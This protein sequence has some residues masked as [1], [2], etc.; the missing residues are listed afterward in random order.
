MHNFANIPKMVQL[1]DE[2]FEKIKRSGLSGV[3]GKDIGREMMRMKNGHVFMNMSSCSYLGLNDF[4]TV[5]QGLLDGLEEAGGIQIAAAPLR[6]RLAIVDE[7]N[8]EFGNFMGC[9]AF[10]TWTCSLASFGILPLLAAGLFTGNKPPVMVYDKNAHFCM[11]YMK[12][13]CADETEVIT[14]NHNDMA[15]LE[16]ICKTKNPVVYLCE[17]LYSTGGVTCLDEIL[18]L[19]EKYGMYILIDEAHGLS[20]VGKN[21]KGLLIDKLGALNDRSFFIASLEKGF[22]AHGGGV[23]LFSDKKLLDIIERYGGPL[24]WSAPVPSMI[25]G[26]TRAC[27]KL[28]ADGTVDN[29]QKILHE[30]V[31]LFDQLMDIKESDLWS[32]VRVIKY[33]DEDELFYTGIRLFE[34]GFYTSTV[35]F[36]TVKGGNSG[37]HIM[38]RANM[39]DEELRKFAGLLKL[40]KLEWADRKRK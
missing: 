35:A 24:E 32:A 21:G 17:S 19:Q 27:L 30:K 10:M 16:K 12:A 28:H 29:L 3:T 5:K 14:I 15:A 20:V 38:L 7:V 37:L 6:V 34:E 13:A 31:R 22:G 23:I 39:E 4:P 9:N 8:E 25:C 26:S 33:P 11:N 36:P 40:I 18:R 2:S 1:A